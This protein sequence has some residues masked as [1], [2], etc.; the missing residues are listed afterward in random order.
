LDIET[1][2][3]A[4]VRICLRDV[5]TR[6]DG[7]RVHGVE[8]HTGRQ[9]DNQRAERFGMGVSYGLNLISICL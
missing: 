1:R 6:N 7:V 4:D 2:N 5:G 3:T 8:R 9:C